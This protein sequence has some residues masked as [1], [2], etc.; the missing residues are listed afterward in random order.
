VEDGGIVE[1]LGMTFWAAAMGD[2][3]KHEITVVGMISRKIIMCRFDAVRAGSN[4][5]HVYV[6]GIELETNDLMVFEPARLTKMER[7][8][9]HPGKMVPM[10]TQWSDRLSCDADLQYGLV[11]RGN[12]EVDQ[13][14]V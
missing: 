7:I 14:H 9:C 8:A 2:R 4:V 10:R 11:V 1:G 13:T 12:Y 6:H 3:Q 5:L